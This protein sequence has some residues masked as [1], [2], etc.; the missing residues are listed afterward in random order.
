MDIQ[1]YGA[2]CI[3]IGNKQARVVIDDNLAELGAKNV[4]KEGD[5]VLFTAAEHPGSATHAARLMLDQPGEYEVAGVSIYG[6]AARSHMDE[7]G[8]QSATIYKIMMDDITVLVTGHI[9]PELSETQLEA[10]GMVDVMLVPVGGNGYTLDGIGAL[11]L[12]KKVEP[13]IVIPTHY[14][15]PKLNFPVPQQPLDAALQALAMEPKE[16]V[17]KLR[18]KPAELADGMELIVLERA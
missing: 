13:K 7:E 8:K 11:K 18:V 3:V 14:E 17:A 4:T 16:T 1:W 15:D 6:L 9:Y 5:I 12:V 2:N 10:I